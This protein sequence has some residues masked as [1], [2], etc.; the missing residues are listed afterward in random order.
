MGLE[1]SEGSVPIASRTPR[2]D[3][4]MQRLWGGTGEGAFV[5][6][7]QEVLLFPP[8][9]HT[10]RSADKAYGL[11]LTWEKMEAPDHRA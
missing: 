10:M 7:A 3:V 4:L 6:R 1:P 11:Y 2:S 9:D 5:P 8:E